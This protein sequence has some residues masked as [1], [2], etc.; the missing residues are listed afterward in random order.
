MDPP[1]LSPARL[2]LILG[3]LFG[4]ANGIATPP[5]ASPDEQKHL[6][7]AYLIS[8]GRLGVPGRSFGARHTVPQSFRKLRSSLDQP[9]APKSPKRFALEHYRKVI[10]QPLEPQYRQ[11]ALSVADKHCPTK[12]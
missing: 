12:R 1:A 2:F 10:A 11:I 5:F 3:A 6:V 7:R 4:L 9:E 8:E